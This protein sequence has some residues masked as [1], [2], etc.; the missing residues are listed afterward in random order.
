M[1]E[2]QRTYQKGAWLGVQRG[3]A[4]QRQDVLRQVQQGLW[5][6]SAVSGHPPQ[7]THDTVSKWS[8]NIDMTSRAKLVCPS[9]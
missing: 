2:G 8:D 3:L 1:G 9:H 4:K 6:P 7:N 5:E